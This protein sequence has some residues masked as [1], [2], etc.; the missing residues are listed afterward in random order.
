MRVAMRR[1]NRA[2]TGAD[3][4]RS[5]NEPDQILRHVIPSVSEGSGRVGGTK[6]C[7][8]AGDAVKLPLFF[9]WTRP[10]IRMFGHKSYSTRMRSI[11][12]RP[13]TLISCPASNASLFLFSI[14]LSVVEKNLHHFPPQ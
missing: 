5:R 14:V 13:S 1:K 9:H 12:E 4:G 2:G 7:L 8:E 11:I 10:N 6:Q 3:A